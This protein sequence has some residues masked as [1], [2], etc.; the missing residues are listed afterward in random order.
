MAWEDAALPKYTVAS[1]IRTTPWNKIGIGGVSPMS[2]PPDSSVEDPATTILFSKR[3]TLLLG[4]KLENQTPKLRA[5]N[6]AETWSIQMMPSTNREPLP[7][8]VRAETI[9]SA[10]RLVGFATKQRR[11]NSTSTSSLSTNPDCSWVT[12]ATPS[13]SLSHLAQLAA[14]VGLPP[15]DA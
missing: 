8:V 3:A 4:T 5:G 12:T 10:V 14:A 7:A 2:I 11:C 9:G 15:R 6:G 1:W 13:G